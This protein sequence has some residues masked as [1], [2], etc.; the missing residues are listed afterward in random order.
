MIIYI[1]IKFSFLHAIIIFIISNFLHVI[2]IYS[3]FLQ[4]IIIFII[5]FLLMKLNGNI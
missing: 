4:V 2:I 1:F 5:N 3:N